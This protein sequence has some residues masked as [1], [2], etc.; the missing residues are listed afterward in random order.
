MAIG[1]VIR[2]SLG[3]LEPFAAHVYRAFFFDLRRLAEHVARLSPGSILEIGCGEG[4]LA[5]ALL[6]VLPNASYVGVDIC[7]TPGRL[8]TGDRAR[9]RFFVADACPFAATHPS[10]FDMVIACDVLHHVAPNAR[11]AFVA[12][13]QE[14]IRPCGTFVLKEWERRRNLIH[15]VAWASDRFVTG[16]RVAYETTEGLR[17]LVRSAAPKLAIEDEQRYSPWRNNVAL[18]LRKRSVED[19]S[20]D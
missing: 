16:D 6:S 7:A 10:S 17:S 2:R 19:A 3:P 5:T 1:P 9:A 20:R 12:A 14:A 18:F 15:L 11:A 8:F 4:A 13:A